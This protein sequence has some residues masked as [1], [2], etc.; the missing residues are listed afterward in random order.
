MNDMTN[1]PR[2]LTSSEVAIATVENSGYPVLPPFDPHEEYPEYTFGSLSKEPNL[3]YGQV[4][5]LMRRLGLDSPNYSKSSW[6]PF[7]GLV[8]PGHRI[9]LKPKW[10]THSSDPSAEE[11]KC[12]Q[13][14]LILELSNLAGEPVTC[15]IKLTDRIEPLPSGK[16][17]YCRR[18]Y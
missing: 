16:H 3:V 15:T 4:R 12:M 10:V 8:L 7:K 11:L 18:D 13:R 9:T 6:N 17:L 1:K 14:R 2:D 5:Q